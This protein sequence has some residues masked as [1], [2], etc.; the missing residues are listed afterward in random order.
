MTKSGTAGKDA[1]KNN[2]LTDADKKTESRPSTS[3]TPAPKIKDGS[4]HPHPGSDSRVSHMCDTRRSSL[5][6]TNDVNSRP[7]RVLV[8]AYHVYCSPVY[9]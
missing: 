2:S 7:M 6:S 8:D 4:A 3:G 9:L 5:L 1:Q